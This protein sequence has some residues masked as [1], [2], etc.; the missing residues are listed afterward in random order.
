ML[1]EFWNSMHLLKRL[2]DQTMEPVCEEFKLTRMEL[3]ILLFLANN[4][5][6]DTARDIIERRR[7]T[8][9]HVSVS[10]RLLEKKYFPGNRKTVHLALLPA[11]SPAVAAGQDAQQR[12]YDLIFR[13]FRDDERVRMGEGFSK[14]AA[15]IRTALRED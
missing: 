13:G 14:I 3:D 7:L 2:Y 12:F 11:S 15:N 5:E 6:F 8:K 1:P 9:S 10:L 4:K